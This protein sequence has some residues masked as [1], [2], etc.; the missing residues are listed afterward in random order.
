MCGS[1][2]RPTAAGVILQRGNMIKREKKHLAVNLW[3]VGLFNLLLVN[4]RYFG[5]KRFK[6][7]M[8]CDTNQRVVVVF[9][10]TN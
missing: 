6:D 4:E 7:Y 8:L 5:N 3:L 2:F 1:D 10:V 9:V